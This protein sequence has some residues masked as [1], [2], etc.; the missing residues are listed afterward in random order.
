[1]LQAKQKFVNLKC[2]LVYKK[3]HFASQKKI[4]FNFWRINKKSV[5]NQ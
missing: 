2:S 4:Y 5:N 1:M 3:I